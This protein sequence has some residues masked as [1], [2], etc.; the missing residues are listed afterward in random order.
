M[1]DIALEILFLRFRWKSASLSRVKP[2]KPNL[3]TLC[4]QLA[5]FE[6]LGFVNVFSDYTVRMR[7]MIPS[8]HGCE[9]SVDLSV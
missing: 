8:T 6:I 9:V 5:V 3:V 7:G 4:I 1:E 2:K